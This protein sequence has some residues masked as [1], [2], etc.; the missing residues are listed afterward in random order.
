MGGEQ[1]K[2]LVFRR[3]LYTHTEIATRTAEKIYRH[4]GTKMVKK[5][6][7]KEMPWQ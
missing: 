6:E 2:E 4:Q 3:I 1:E 7:G 5:Q